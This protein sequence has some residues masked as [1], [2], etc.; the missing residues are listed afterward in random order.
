M[1]QRMGIHS[2]AAN[3][4]HPA[5][6]AE[7]RRRLWWSFVLF[8][9]R[10]A[11]MADLQS[12]LLVP[13]WDCKIPLN[14]NDFDLRPEMKDPPAV[15]SQSSE[16]LFAVVRSEHG[17]FVR[18]SPF[19]LD[20]INP[21]LKTLA[22]TSAG[23]ASDSDQLAMLERTIED[24]YLTSCQPQNPLHF[25]TTW[26]A[27]ANIA[28]SRFVHHLAICS[29]ATEPPTDAQRLAGI[30]YAL[31]LLDCDTKLMTS[32]LIRGFH[33]H[34]YL[35]FPFPAYVHLVENL[36]TRPHD[37][38]AETAWKVMGDNCSARFLDVENRD[39]PLEKK[40]NPFF[41]I[42]AGV[43]LRAWAAR[44]AGSEQSGRKE[45]PPLIVTQVRR[46]MAR[47]EELSRSITTRQ[48]GTEMAIA[49]DMTPEPMA[50]G[51]FDPLYTMS[52]QGVL[53]TSPGPFPTPPEQ[54]VMGFYGGQWGGP[55]ANWNSMVNHGW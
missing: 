8:D 39:N 12:G 7:L 43:V 35:N 51:S 20:F 38:F 32:P 47:M 21:V 22:K 45:V 37:H 16:S 13:T 3:S 31:T 24:K 15:F 50:F 6:E 53:N 55:S 4:K 48:Q 36:R 11:E 2:E 25:M 26:T 44:E 41:K 40:D 52:A 14:V 9:A 33:W 10:I 29:R 42:F 30:S 54:H 18:H 5:L 49:D 34:I 1:A 27:R 23:E 46:R 17:N 28:K 19:Y